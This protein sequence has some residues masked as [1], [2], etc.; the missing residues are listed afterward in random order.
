M[1]ELIPKFVP[2]ADL[3]DVMRREE[4]AK[5]SYRL[6]DEK[7]GC[8]AGCCTGV[9]FYPETEYGKG[10]VHDDQ[11]G[12]F[13][14]AGNGTAK[15][16]ETEFKIYPGVSFIAPAGVRHVIKRDADSDAVE[17]FWFHSAV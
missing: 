8:V 5:K 9:S 4:Q 13:V 15:V 14:I 10:G 17:V 2:Y 6:L 16:G 12:F 1:S 7:N 3:N 11:E